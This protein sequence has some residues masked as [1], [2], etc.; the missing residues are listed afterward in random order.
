MYEQ[1]T[2]AISDNPMNVGR[3]RGR[4][5][6]RPPITLASLLTIDIS[7]HFFLS[8]I[9]LYLM[10]CIIYESLFSLIIHPVFVEYS[11]QYRVFVLSSYIIGKQ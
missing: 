4:V 1:L 11:R 2:G 9:S 7:A 5:P 10:S 6:E 3:G 8:V